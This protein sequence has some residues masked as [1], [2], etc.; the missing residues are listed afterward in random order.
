MLTSKY[1]ATVYQTNVAVIY[2]DL[3]GDGDVD[4]DDFAKG[5]ESAVADETYYSAEYAVFF[6]A[7]DVNGDGY[8]DVLDS[9]VIGRIQK[10]KMTVLVAG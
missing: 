2:G 3:D 6:M 5:K 8:I 4:A 1:I 10:G 7:N 9:W